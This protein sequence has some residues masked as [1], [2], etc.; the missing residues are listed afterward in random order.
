MGSIFQMARESIST[1]NLNEA[2]YYFAKGGVL[3][4]VTT[5]TKSLRKYAHRPKVRQTIWRFRFSAVRRN[6]INSWWE[7]RAT[8]RISDFEKYRTKLKKIAYEKKRG[9]MV[10]TFAHHI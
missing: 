4:N 7:G 9:A 10:N 3:E 1:N 8:M 5:I 2:T 6:V